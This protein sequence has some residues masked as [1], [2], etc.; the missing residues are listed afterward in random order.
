MPR[1]RFRQTKSQADRNPS[2]PGQG[3]VLLTRVSSSSAT[4]AASAESRYRSEAY[5]LSDTGELRFTVCHVPQMNRRVRT[6]FWAFVQEEA[7]YS[8]Y[9][10]SASFSDA[11]SEFIRTRMSNQGLERG[12]RHLSATYFKV[13]PARPVKEQALGLINSNSF[14]R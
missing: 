3:N 4:A 11:K 8:I 12:A 9:S 13:N 14:K 5:L 1:G 7:H 2:I 6:S 10:Y